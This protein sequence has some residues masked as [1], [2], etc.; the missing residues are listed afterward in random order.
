[1]TYHVTKL[2]VESVASPTTH[3]LVRNLGSDPIAEVLLVFFRKLCPPENDVNIHLCTGETRYL[4]YSSSGWVVQG[5]V[6]VPEWDIDMTSAKARL[7]VLH[8]EHGCVAVLA[9]KLRCHSGHKCLHNHTDCRQMH[10]LTSGIRGLVWLT[11]GNHY[12]E[13]EFIR[14]WK[15]ED[16]DRMH[17]QSSLLWQRTWACPCICTFWGLHHIHGRLSRGPLFRIPFAG[18]DSGKDSREGCTTNVGIVTL[19]CWTQEHR[20]TQ[21]GCRRV[22]CGRGCQGGWATHRTWE[23]KVDSPIQTPTKSASSL[24]YCACTAD[25]NLHRVMWGMP[26]AWTPLA[27]CILC[28]VRCCCKRLVEA[29]WLLFLLWVYGQFVH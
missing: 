10:A 23:E 3:L 9:V 8:F 4:A 22:V 26:R 29:L 12:A 2:L 13:D 15:G 7:I 21:G 16:R 14:E 19:A 1:V 20:G 27:L 18:S 11:R 25:T 28:T 17:G 5:K 6:G 24:L